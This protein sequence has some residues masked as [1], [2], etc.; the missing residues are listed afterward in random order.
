MPPDGAPRA[1]SH[2]LVPLVSHTERTYH[3]HPI[4][5]H[6]GT[7][8]EYV[9]PLQHCSLPRRAGV[10]P[11][12][13]ASCTNHEAHTWTPCVYMSCPCSYAGPTTGGP[14]CEEEI[15]HFQWAGEL[16]PDPAA[17]EEALWTTII[18]G[19]PHENWTGGAFP[20]IRARQRISR[21][22]IP[23]PDLQSVPHPRRVS[24]ST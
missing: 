8:D 7:G 20:K 21:P 17:Q 6:V 11:L 3:L 9:Y 13:Q 24:L 18:C 19:W 16:P 22:S 14:C 5:G 4:P 2:H 10:P 23:K 15:A 1:E 12:W